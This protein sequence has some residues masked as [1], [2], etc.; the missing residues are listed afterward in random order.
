[1]DEAGITNLRPI[2]V[3]RRTLLDAAIRE[4]KIDCRFPDPVQSYKSGCLD[5]QLFFS[6]GTTPALQ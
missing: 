4:G 5:Q 2:V 3:Q 1:M 6:H